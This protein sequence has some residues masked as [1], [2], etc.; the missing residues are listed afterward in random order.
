VRAAIEVNR[1]KNVPSNPQCGASADAFKFVATNPVLQ[2]LANDR[3]GAIKVEVAAVK[4]LLGGYAGNGPAAGSE[5][6]PAL[7]SVEIA[8]KSWFAQHDLH[9]G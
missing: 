4:A 1:P 5:H 9:V 7:E 6:A 3:R 2:T 8:V